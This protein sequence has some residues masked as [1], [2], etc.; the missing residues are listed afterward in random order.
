MQMKNTTKNIYNN[1]M[2]NFAFFDKNSFSHSKHTV[3]ECEIVCLGKKI[4]ELG[5][6]DI[7]Y[8]VIS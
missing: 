6:L 8:Y 4:L 2:M 3:H 5:E 7:R 1:L